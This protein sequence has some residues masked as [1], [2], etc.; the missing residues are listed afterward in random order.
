MFGIMR[1]GDIDY[2]SLTYLVR[3]KNPIEPKD[4]VRSCLRAK[5][6]I[7][8]LALWNSCIIQMSKKSKL[9][10]LKMKQKLIILLCHDKDGLKK[11]MQLDCI[12]LRK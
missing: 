9:I 8:F 7:D 10:P 6:N 1:M 12:K 5:T 2:I 3:Y 4:L 11:Q